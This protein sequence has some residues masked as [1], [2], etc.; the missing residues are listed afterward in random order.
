M[1]QKQWQQ[2]H[3]LLKLTQKK[4]SKKKKKFHSFFYTFSHYKA[5]NTNGGECLF[6]LFLFIYFYCFFFSSLHKTRKKLTYA[7]FSGKETEKF[8]FFLKTQ[9]C[10]VGTLEKKGMHSEKKENVADLA[11]YAAQHM[12]SLCPYVM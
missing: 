4:K 12:S 11:F 10:T 9:N 7:H 8:F 2:K 5:T 1:K 6:W 3:K